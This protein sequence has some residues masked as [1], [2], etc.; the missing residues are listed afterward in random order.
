MAREGKDRGDWLR[1]GRQTSATHAIEKTPQFR[2][3]MERFAERAG[4]R[5]SAT[6]GAAFTATIAPGRNAQG[7]AALAGHEGEAAAALSSEGLGAQ[8]AILFDR[9]LVEVLI[10]AMFGLAPAND[11]A[12]A[13]DARTPTALEL[14]M[15]RAVAGRLAAAFCDAFAPVADFDLDVADAVLI[16]DDGLLGPKDAPA[17]L[18]PVEIKA[19]T[20]AF[21]LKLLL[22]HPFLTPLA[23]A[24]ARGPAP[25][26]AK[27]D[28]QWSSRMERRVTGASLTL[29]AI[30]DE[31][32]MSLADVSGLRVG[33][34][35]PLS[36]G[37][38]DRVRIECGER[39]VFV[40]ALGER[41]GRYALEI[42]DIIARSVEGAYPSA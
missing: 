40:C 14:R 19:P 25:G 29:T 17:L 23:A 18:A 24:F 31:F 26:A 3:S 15:I 41:N 35:L 13:N 1:E 2:A 39:G 32:Q 21:N 8:M 16:E 42:E 38:Q 7:F 30:L 28:P 36:E 33:H 11:S 4:E 22:P 37:G 27:L 6:F 20:G 10:G 9:G 12:G 5:L 34:V